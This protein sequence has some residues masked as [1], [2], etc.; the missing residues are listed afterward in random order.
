MKHFCMA[1]VLA[2]L[3]LCV[4]CS[5]EDYI[6]VITDGSE[7]ATVAGM[8]AIEADPATAAFAPILVQGLTL[9][10]ETA[11]DIL[12]GNN[13]ANTTLTL[14]Q[15]LNLA[16]SQDPN[17]AKY[18]TLINFVLPILE[19]IPGISGAMNTQVSQLD[20]TVI[21]DVTAFFTGIQIGL[22]DAPGTTPQQ[23]IDRS[24]LL[25]KAVRS[26]GLGK[27]NPQALVNALKGLPAKK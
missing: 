15:L 4:G 3:G 20:P 6:T 11:L 1:A 13:P 24:P 9:L 22:G 23:I 2:L 18:K 7:A 5:Q 8:L 16:F 26:S 19:D 27:F 21:A 25:K 14:Q 17:L 10:D 12:A